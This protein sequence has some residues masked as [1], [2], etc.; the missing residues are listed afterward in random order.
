[1]RLTILPIDSPCAGEISAGP[2]PCEVGA[3]H[4]RNKGHKGHP[5]PLEWSGILEVPDVL[6]LKPVPLPEYP[7]SVVKRRKSPH[8]GPAPRPSRLSGLH[9]LGPICLVGL[10]TVQSHAHRLSSGIPSG[11]TGGCVRVQFW[12][13][14]GSIAKPESSTARYGGNTSC[15][16]VR[17]A[18]PTLVVVDC[19]TAHRLMLVN[20]LVRARYDPWQGQTPA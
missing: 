16:E 5:V 12:G 11:L 7:W 20:H 1:M 9:L 4:K 15:I 19:G 6:D 2:R 10:E 8:P 17:L 13:T 18:R 14:R 3:A